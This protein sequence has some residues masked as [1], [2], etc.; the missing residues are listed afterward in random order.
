MIK[1]KRNGFTLTEVLITVAVTGIIFSVGPQMFTQ[2][3]RFV[4]ISQKRIEIQREARVV[5]STINRNLRMA[6]TSS[7]QIDRFAANQPYCSR[8]AFQRIDGVKYQ[9]YQQGN[10]LIMVHT[11]AGR[12]AR[13]I[14]TSSLK[15]M[16]FVPPRSEDLSMI[17]VS[18]TLEVQITDAKTKAL[19]MA[20]EK[21]MVMNE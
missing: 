16:A 12:S 1:R 3:N 4:K 8:I 19:H 14:L 18:V 21:V 5:L 15:Y 20:S 17:S 10:R 11:Q 6:T 13:Q 2:I 9:F 7:I